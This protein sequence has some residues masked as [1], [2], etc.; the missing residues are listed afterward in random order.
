[1]PP[2][3]PITPDPAPALATSDPVEV[4]EGFLQHPEP[5]L[6][7]EA[8]QWRAWAGGDGLVG[9]ASSWV[10]RA[11]VEGLALRGDDAARQRLVELAEQPGSDPWVRGLAAL[12]HPV[13]AMQRALASYRTEPMAWRRLPLALGAWASGDPEAREAL[14]RDLRS[15]MLDWNVDLMVAIGGRED[16]DLAPA[17]AEA[18]RQAE[19]ELRLAI[20]AARLMVGDEAAAEAFG[21]VI[22]GDSTEARLEAIDLLVQV[23]TEPASRLLAQAAERGPEIVTTYV[24]LAGID[25]GETKLG[26]L[27]KAMASENPEIRELAMRFAVPGAASPLWRPRALV[28]TKRRD[29]VAPLVADG[30]MDEDPR[31]RLEAVRS[32]ARLGLDVTPVAQALTRDANPRVR[33]AAAG[34]LG[35][36]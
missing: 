24:E 30:L 27:R 20:A 29:E 36:R 33:L 9:D 5:G 17:L 11:E 35:L 32:A 23:Q 22:R 26:R 15:G 13:P 28:D 4:L 12:V 3:G 16:P 2:T 8:V 21:P 25:R 18:E 31:V 1:A 14:V 7:G 19:P 10:Q 34:Y 6:R